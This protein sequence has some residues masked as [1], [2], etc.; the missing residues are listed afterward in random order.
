MTNLRTIFSFAVLGIMTT[1]GGYAAPSVKKFGGV[2]ISS[3][4][5]NT[6]SGI[7]SATIN[8]IGSIRGVKA[9]NTKSAQIVKTTDKA[10][11]VRLSVGKYLHNSGAANGIIKTVNTNSPSNTGISADETI[12][13]LIQRVNLLEAKIEA[14]QPKITI[15]DEDV[16][17]GKVVKGLVIN[18][19]NTVELNK[20]NVKIP[21]GNENSDTAVPI[22]IEF[23]QM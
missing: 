10:G 22:W 18:D 21:V 14:M 5:G 9:V 17:D 7:K 20:V 13:N 15:Q 11:T 23:K 16:S 3:V 19:D 2:N 8:R 12:Q 1:V 6:S 4:A